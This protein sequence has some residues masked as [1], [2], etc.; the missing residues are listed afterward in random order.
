MTKTSRQK[1]VLNFDLLSSPGSL[2]RRCHQSSRSIYDRLMGHTSLSRQQISL[3]ISI[4]HNPA[5]TH[6]QLSNTSGFERNTLAEMIDRL[7][8]ANYATRERSEHD[9]RAYAVDL[10]AQGRELL[11]RHIEDIEAIQKEILKPLPPEMR[12]DFIRC[13]RLI[14]G[15]EGGRP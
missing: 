7:I 5:S 12:P 3:M 4:Y 15:V 11:E 10:T 9:G 13:L 2:L 8:V 14:A 1:R 6:S